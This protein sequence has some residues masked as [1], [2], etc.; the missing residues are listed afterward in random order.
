MV[1][2]SQAVVDRNDHAPRRVGEPPTGGVDRLGRSQDPAAAVKVNQGRL[3]ARS[4]RRVNPD[5][6]TAGECAIL[7]LGDGLGRTGQRHHAD[8]PLRA[9]ST[10]IVSKPAAPRFLPSF[11]ET[12]VPADRAAGR[13][14]SI[15][16]LGRVEASGI[17]DAA[18]AGASG[19]AVGHSLPSCARGPCTRRD[20]PRPRDTTR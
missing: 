4:R 16:L 12:P 5:A 1:L 10:G 8:E 17:A 2:G 11:R 6:W 3:R 9:S 15:G 14:P 18:R 7:D 13:L 20:L 19:K